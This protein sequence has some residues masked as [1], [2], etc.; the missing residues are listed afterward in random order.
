MCGKG[1]YFCAGIY[2]VYF[3]FFKLIFYIFFQK[4][5]DLALES[6]RDGPLLGEPLNK[7]FAGL[8]FF[9]KQRKKKIKWRKK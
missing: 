1:D 4:G 9:L 5:A 3:L 2:T 6:S 7:T 8:F